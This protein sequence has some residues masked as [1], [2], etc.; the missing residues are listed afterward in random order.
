MARGFL[1]GTS[2]GESAGWQIAVVFA[3]HWY[4]G[5]LPGCDDRWHHRSPETKV[6]RT[7][8]H[9]GL[10]YGAR[11]HGSAGVHPIKDAGMAAAIHM[12]ARVQLCGFQRCAAPIIVGAEG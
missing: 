2:L 8:H 11:L 3:R 1:R 9:H 4:H 7:L 12:H 10:S 5:S 6:A